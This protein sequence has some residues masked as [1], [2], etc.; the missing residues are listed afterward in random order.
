MKIH[1][2]FN[3]FAIFAFS[4]FSPSQHQFSSIFHLK[5]VPRL[6]R[7][8]LWG[9]SWP[10]MAG[11]V[12][13]LG[14]IFGPSNPSDTSLGASWNQFQP[15]MTSKTTSTRNFHQKSS[16]NQHHPILPIHPIFPILPILP[17]LV[18]FPPI[19]NASKHPSGD[20]GMR[21]AIELMLI[22]ANYC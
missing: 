2:F 1:W 13:L 22:N 7:L 12:R 4:Y 8:P 6:P 15:P 10:I 17:I 14:Q 3:D 19:L 5:M 20:G 9:P 16:K 11:V 18:I 21:G